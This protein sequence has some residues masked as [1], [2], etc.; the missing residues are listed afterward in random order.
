MHQILPR[1]GKK[2][3]K[4]RACVCSLRI[5]ARN[6]HVSCRHLW[7]VLFY[8]IFLHHLIKSTIFGKTLSGILCYFDLL[9]HLSF[10]VEL[11]DIH[12]TNVIGR[13][14]KYL[15]CLSG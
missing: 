15:L 11:N 8:H 12:I 1:K 10:K 5:P 9:R 7:S 6:A 14:V 13:H 4:L 2:S 3:Y